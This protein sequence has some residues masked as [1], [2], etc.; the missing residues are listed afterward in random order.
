MAS[1][2][3]PTEGVIDL[4]QGVGGWWKSREWSLSVCLEFTLGASNLCC[5]PPTPSSLEDEDL[6]CVPGLGP[7]EVS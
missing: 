1:E 7:P 4:T 3:A 2:A 6:P 5:L